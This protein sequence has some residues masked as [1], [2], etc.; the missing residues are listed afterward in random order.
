M[1]NGIYYGITGKVYIIHR[2]IL[3]KI[4]FWIELAF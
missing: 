2:L 3:L 4:E 1:G